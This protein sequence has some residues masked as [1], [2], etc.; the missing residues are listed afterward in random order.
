MPLIKSPSD[1]AFKKNVSAEVRS[2]RPQAQ[3][4]AIA[5]RI[6]RDAKRK[7]MSDGGRV[8][9][10]EN[11]AVNSVSDAW[12]KRRTG[13]ENRYIERTRLYPYRGGLGP[14]ASESYLARKRRSDMLESERISDAVPRRPGY[15]DGG[16]IPAPP[17]FARNAARNLERSGFIRS[18]VAGRSDKL[19]MGLP[20]GAYV[21]PADVVSGVGQ[22]N[23]LAGANAFNK[24]FR[25]GP[26]GSAMPKVGAMR[27]PS[28]RQRRFAAGGAA[29]KPVD[30]MAAG[31]EYVVGPEIVAELG[32][33]DMDVGHS[34]LDAMVKEIRQKNIKTLRRLPGPKKP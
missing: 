2:G 24:M 32:H 27:A 15:A 26:Y 23:S 3:A 33:G 1:A 19:P 4:L 29:D 16:G 13:G 20:A 31:G 5:Y 8:D 18:P 25:L 21:I 12:N 30:V 10:G 9:D 34:I 7:K 22:G 11:Y 28:M 17:F 14:A 6:Q